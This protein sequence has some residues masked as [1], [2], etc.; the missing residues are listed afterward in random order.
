MEAVSL[1]KENRLVDAIKELGSE[2]RKHPSDIKLRTFL[3]ELLCF[4]GQYDR[5]EKQLE[6]LVA[7]TGAP[8]LGATLYRGLLHAQRRREEVFLQ[9]EE[10]P[11][12]T[13]E[14]PSGW[15][16]DSSFASCVDEDWRVGACLEVFAGGDY[17]RVPF[18][19]VERLETSEPKTLRD[20][21]WLPARLL[22]KSQLQGAT[23]TAEVHLP[24]L[25]PFSWKHPDEAVRLGRVSATEVDDDG[26][27]IPFGA[28]IFLF[29]DD[30]VPVLEIRSLVFAQE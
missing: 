15:V 1:F 5:A 6:I 30:E 20:L 12:E 19:A 23:D 21:L 24:V 16:N 29:G 3:F 7:N 25:A 11:A 14:G 13:E 27:I 2:L 9:K 4:A 26:E 8:E 22:A 18:N 17:V 10:L 28:K